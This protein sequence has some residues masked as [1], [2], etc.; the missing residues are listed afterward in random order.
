MRTSLPS[1]SDRATAC[2]VRTRA[3]SVAAEIPGQLDVEEVEV[4]V[5][6]A[7]EQLGPGVGQSLG[8]LVAPGL[9]FG[10]QGAQLLDGVDAVLLAAVDGP[11]AVRLSRRA[12]RRRDAPGTGAGVRRWSCPRRYCTPSRNGALRG[13][14]ERSRPRVAKVTD[15]TRPAVTGA[16][17]RR[18]ALVSRWRGSDGTA[19]ARP[20][21]QRDRHG[22]ISV[23]GTAPPSAVAPAE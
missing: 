2:G 20:G 13:D 17:S 10:L 22:P 16:D 6:D 19:A 1:D 3:L 18:P 14:Y 5:A 7:L 21:T 12:R 8:E 11:S 23:T 4:D 9:V 15:S